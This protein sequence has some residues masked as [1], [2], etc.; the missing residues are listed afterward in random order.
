MGKKSLVIGI[1]LISFSILVIIR[2]SAAD[3]SEGFTKIGAFIPSFVLFALP[4]LVV[5]IFF[6]RKYFRSRK[7]EKQFSD[8]QNY[9][10]NSK[11][12]EP[13]KQQQ[14]T[15]NDTQFWVC[16]NCGTDIQMKDGRQYCYSCEIYLSI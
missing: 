7:T 6:L 2:T 14:N 12:Y 13:P 5:G 9:Q 3:M 10:D 16:P 15:E 1:I 8:S 4:S 11:K